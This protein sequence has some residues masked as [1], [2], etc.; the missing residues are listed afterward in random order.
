MLHDSGLPKFLWAE[1][2]AHT[3]YLKNCTWTC[4]TGETTPY[5][6]LY[7]RKLDLSNIQP[8][9]CK[10]RVHNTGGLK[11]DSC[12]KI[13]RWMGFDGETR[14][15]HHIYWPERRMV[16]VERSVKF[17]FDDNE[18][19]VGVLLLEGESRNVEQQPNITQP[20]PETAKTP[21]EAPDA[22]NIAEPDIVKPTEPTE[23]RGRC[24]QKESKYVRMLRE[25]TRVTGE[26][27]AYC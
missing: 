25:G 9:G 4:T 18:V 20:I 12:S 13:G 19:N 24:I 8:W 17:N 15:G 3:V 16:T 21:I 26:S 27:R 22:K 10:V 7:G 6:I 14:D 2:T 23:G 5:E 1:A 11:L